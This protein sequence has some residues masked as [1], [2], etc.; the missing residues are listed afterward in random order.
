[1]KTTTSTILHMWTSST[2]EHDMWQALLAPY[3]WVDGEFGTM[4]T[5][6]GFITCCEELADKPDTSPTVRRVLRRYCSMV[7]QKKCGDVCLNHGLGAHA[8]SLPPK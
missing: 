7:K 5:D 8:K 6:T 3:S 1:M 4:C 2:T